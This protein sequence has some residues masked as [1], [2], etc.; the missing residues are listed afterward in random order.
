MIGQKSVILVEFN[1]LSPVLVDRYI[2]EG[3]LPNFRRFYEESHVY[4]T[5]AGEQPPYLNPWIQ[6][7]TVHTGLSYAEHRVFHL[8]DGQKLKA[9]RTWDL[10]SE[11]GMPVWV[12]GSMNSAHVSKLNGYFLP[13]PW[14]A[15]IAAQPENLDPYFRFVRTN[16][17]EHSNSQVPLGWKDYAKFFSFMTTHGLSVS[18][19]RAG[20][21]QL[22]SERNG[23][24]RWKRAVILDKL[25]FDMFRSVYRKVK[26]RLATFFSNSTAH[27]QH[28]YWRHMNPEAFAIKPT[29]QELEEYNTAILV[30]YQEMD[31]L[32]GRFFELAGDEATL[33]LCTA[34]SQQPC[35]IYEEQGGKVVYRPRDFETLLKF[36]GVTRPHSVA[37]VMAEE[38]HVRFEKEA[39]AA[40]A[41]DR[42]R[43]L[44][45]GECPALRVE[46][47]EAG[48]FAGCAFKTQLPEDT[49]LCLKGSDRAAPFFDIFYRL[50][51]TLKSG[52]HHPDG[53]LWIRKADRSHRVYAQKVPLTSIAP[54]VLN[55]LSVPR[56]EFMRESP[57]PLA[58]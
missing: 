38:F 6:W 48:V 12:C 58:A 1:E 40:D 32:L 8:G 18:T 3:H 14:A 39:D 22:L 30:G 21:R 34:L 23:R 19:I 37:P 24:N 44:Y 7:V 47:R 10:V 56:G 57:L 36:A 25:Q 49:T 55:L 53:M 50:Y 33:I 5:D 17:V 26:P 43:A 27:F 35:L 31:K 11:A 51:G 42:L 29:S 46:V 13:D 15:E 4:T 2:R 16:V 41:A 28:Y 54:T 52:M 20:M 9:K 45:V